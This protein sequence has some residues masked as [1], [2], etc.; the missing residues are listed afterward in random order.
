MIITVV[1]HSKHLP[2][3]VVD[4][5]KN[6]G[7]TNFDRFAQFCDNSNH[8]CAKQASFRSSRFSPLKG[9]NHTSSIYQSNSLTD[10]KTLSCH[11]GLGS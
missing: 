3:K 2:P 5:S 1:E 6:R 8:G 10:N 11:F 4:C 9:Q 7:R